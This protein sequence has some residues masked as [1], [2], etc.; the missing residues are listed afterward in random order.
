MGAISVVMDISDIRS[1]AF[2]TTKLILFGSAVVLFLSG[3]Y[4]YKFVGKYV[5]VFEKLR[6]SM[7]EQ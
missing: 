5:D 2:T 7:S 1:Y 4:M 3:F 6:M